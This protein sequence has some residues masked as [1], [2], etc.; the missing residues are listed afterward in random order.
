MI[1]AQSSTSAGRN[2][3]NED[4]GYGAGAA[5]DKEVENRLIH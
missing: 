2:M 4:V 1:D 3:T 5:G